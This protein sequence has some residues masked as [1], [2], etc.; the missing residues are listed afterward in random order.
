MKTVKIVIISVICSILAVIGLLLLMG[1]AVYMQQSQ[2]TQEIC[3]W[4][5]RHGGIY[6]T[7]CL[8][9]GYSEDDYNMWAQF[10]TQHD[11]FNGYWKE[12]YG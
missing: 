12:K 3:D 6:H 7:R 10:H 8:E 9:Q 5:Y 4:S 11:G 2:L 1:T